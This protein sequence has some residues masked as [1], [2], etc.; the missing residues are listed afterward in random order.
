MAISK[1]FMRIMMCDILGN[2]HRIC[3]F[4]KYFTL[5]SIFHLR[6]SVFN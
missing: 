1:Y 4:K 6:N 5:L 3:P 2:T